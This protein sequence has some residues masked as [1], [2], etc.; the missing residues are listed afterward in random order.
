MKVAEIMTKD[1]A[2]CVSTASLNEAAQMMADHDCGCIPVLDDV[3]NRRPIGTITDRDIV[4]RALAQNKDPLNMVVGDVMTD[5]PVTVTIGETQ[6]LTSAT[7]RW[8]KIRFG[9]F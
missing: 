3:T 7:E 5:Q 2:C 9:A 8:K 6:A 1:P 4:I